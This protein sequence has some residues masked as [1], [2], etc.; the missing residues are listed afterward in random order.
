MVS[1]NKERN[2]KQCLFLNNNKKTDQ[3]FKILRK[4]N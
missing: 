3:T 1:D 2:K 4:L